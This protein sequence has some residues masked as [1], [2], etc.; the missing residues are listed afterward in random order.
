MESLDGGALA[1]GEQGDGRGV[2]S[3]SVVALVMI[4]LVG[5]A[6]ALLAT[7]NGLYL[8]PDSAS[9]I[10]SARQVLQGKG[11]T[12]PFG[13]HGPEPLVHF[14]IG[15]PAALALLG[16]SGVDPL[17]G[18]R[19]VNAVL[20]G[21]NAVLVGYTVMRIS[22]G[23]MTSLL[24]S[25]LFLGAP[26]VLHA[27]TSAWSEPLFIC[28]TF[29]GLLF[30]TAHLN[31]RKRAPLAIAGFALALALLTRWT[32]APFVAAASLSLL[33]WG[34]GTRYAR[35]RAAICFG[36]LVSVPAGLLMLRNFLVRGTAT[37]RVLA[38]HPIAVE[39]IAQGLRTVTWWAVP[40]A[41]TG[42]LGHPTAAVLA[43][44]AGA[45]LVAGVVVFRKAEAKCVPQPVVGP[46]VYLVAAAA[47]LGFL[48]VSISF[49]DA[50]SP[51]DERILLPVFALAVILGAWLVGVLLH[52]ILTTRVLRLLVIVIAVG[53]CLLYARRGVRWVARRASDG[54]GYSASTWQ[55]SALM[56]EVGG[57]P[58]DAIIYSN[59]P[60]AIYLV[61]ER[62]AR[63][64][65]RS[66][67]PWT[68]LKNA[69]YQERMQAVG[70]RLLE[71]DGYVVFFSR[72][73]L[74]GMPTEA[75]LVE[76][77]P[78]EAISCDALGTMYRLDRS[79]R[80]PLE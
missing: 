15:F 74:G 27:H 7:Q 71:T 17:S 58:A 64:L 16:L 39:R 59:N 50:R 54:G 11:F 29:L 79:G 73:G 57:L 1:G 52:T 67:I 42:L 35:V 28:F 68:G 43:S 33:L 51:L 6:A 36:A 4:S 26:G 31:G 20:L 30:L 44:L 78:V 8:S 41:V 53:Y 10:G 19:W 2:R 80:A 25:V 61:A 24:A 75:D 65:P 23:A 18:A 40:S 14:P 22:R 70:Q 37:N 48:V 38:Y 66:T 21:L 13:A 9:Y 72:S 76:A 3:W 55:Q 49:L 12:V 77:V 45:A 62:E 69:A 32:A 56:R 5:V 63:H 47:Y 46:E 34:T 60:T